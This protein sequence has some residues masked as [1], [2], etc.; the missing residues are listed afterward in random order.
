MANEYA[1]NS[2]DLTAVADAIRTKGE[3]TESLAF[4][5]GFVTAIENISAGAAL[6]FEVVGSTEQPENPAE[7]TIWVNTDTEITGWTFS[8][9]QPSDPS[10]GMVW[11]VNGVSDADEFNAC[12]D[13]NII[14]QVAGAK[15]YISGAWAI[16][17]V[18]VCQNEAWIVATP[19]LLIGG[20]LCSETTGGWKIIYRNG[21]ATKFSITDSG[22]TST[23]TDIYPVANFQTANMIDVTNYNTLSATFNVTKA[24]NTNDGG[25]IVGLG[26]TKLTEGAHT[27][28]SIYTSPYYCDAGYTRNALTGNNI[29]I[30]L[31]VADLSGTYYAMVIFNG[32]T[33]VCSEVKLSG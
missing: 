9:N 15:Q 6:N 24:Y 3:T 27:S 5:G 17:S 16:K 1:V 25:Y 30:T 11:I 26:T 10:E 29:T 18:S 20:D 13:V 2:A 12:E 8:R 23:A 33:A 31:N 14:V 21:H 28:G 7:N 19:Y 22:F 4:P 32:C